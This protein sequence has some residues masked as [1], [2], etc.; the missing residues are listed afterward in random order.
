LETGNPAP[1][2]T[3]DD[4]TVELDPSAPT[5]SFHLNYL[6][7]ANKCHYVGIHALLIARLD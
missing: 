6:M 2:K 3:A 7:L 5:V 1:A 4:N